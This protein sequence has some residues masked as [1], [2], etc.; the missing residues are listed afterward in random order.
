MEKEDREPNLSDLRGSAEIE[1]DADVIA[2]LWR[3]KEGVKM[4]VGKSRMGTTG[5]VP[6]AVDYDTGRFTEVKERP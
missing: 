3:N 2:F 5:P 6:I 4:K 1:A